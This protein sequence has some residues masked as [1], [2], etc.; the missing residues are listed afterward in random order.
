MPR[1][2]AGVPKRALQQM[3]LPIIPYPWRPVAPS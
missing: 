1:N 3:A 2:V